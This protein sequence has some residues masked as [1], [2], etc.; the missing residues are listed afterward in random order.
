MP[1]TVAAGFAA[2]V[3]LAIAIILSVL[4]GSIDFLTLFMFIGGVL[5]FGYALQW[6]GQDP[7]RTTRKS[8][9]A[10]WLHL[11][12]APMMVHPIF[13]L[14]DIFSG[15]VSLG[16]ASVVVAIYIVIGLISLAVDRRAL[17]VSALIY[18]L[19]SLS[20]LLEH[21]GSVSTGFA[22]AAFLIG[23][24]LLLLSAFWHPSRSY[25]MKSFP[26]ALQKRFAPF[27]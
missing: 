3:G 1:I 5:A 6:D 4:P 7:S 11:L 24:G 15:Q 9:I 27:N 14:L 17:M 18:V 13:S 19:V 23:G 16:K 2:L 25:L 10:F 20:R 8:D 26:L 12:A 22:I 21:V